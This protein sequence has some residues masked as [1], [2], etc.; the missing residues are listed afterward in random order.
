[1]DYYYTYVRLDGLIFGDSLPI[2]MGVG[3]TTYFIIN[4]TICKFIISK[5]ES[6]SDKDREDY[7]ELDGCEYNIICREVESDYAQIVRESN[8]DIL[9][10]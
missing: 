8:L 1:M 6:I 7:P 5:W 4:D 10:T 2:L 9:L 3:S